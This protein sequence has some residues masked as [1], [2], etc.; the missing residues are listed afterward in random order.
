MAGPTQEPHIQLG[1]TPQACPG[2]LLEG[3][4]VRAELTGVAVAGDP[5]FPPVVVAWPHGWVAVDADGERL[6]L[7]GSRRVVA[8]VGD[9]VSAGGGF[10]GPHDWFYPCGEMT[11]TPAS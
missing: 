8:R 9:A 1:V 5:N 7:D 6:L 11:F 2:A 4:L 10:G 3:L